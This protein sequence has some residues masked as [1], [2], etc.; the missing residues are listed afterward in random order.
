MTETVR[1]EQPLNERIRTLLR[2]EFLFDQMA[3]F[4]AGSSTW[5]TRS[6]LQVLF[7][8]LNITSRNELKSELLKE[9][10]RHAA[11]LNRLR[12]SPGVDTRAVEAF[13]EE[14]GRVTRRYH[15]LDS[16]AVEE[17][18]QNDFL[19]GIRQRSG[20]PGGTCKFDL[21]GLYHW[22]Q[23][24][25]GERAAQ[26][27]VWFG[28]FSPMEAAVRLVLRL[29]RESAVPGDEIALSGFFQK[30]LDSSAPS[31]LVQ[32]ILP[33]ERALFPE[34]S[35]GRH[36]VSIRF[37]EQPTPERRPTQ[38]TDDVEFRFVCCIL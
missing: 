36:R 26:L 21:P 1:Y 24:D 4:A 18:R 25:S 23:H 5:D 15:E 37:M 9:L 17:V 13:L 7:E 2:L 33:R 35:G 12:R 22:L 29:V 11:T 10:E 3:H 19:N 32:V 34:I 8:T 30:A 38:T 6:G 20:I 14:I 16:Q 27:R 31:Q 28:P